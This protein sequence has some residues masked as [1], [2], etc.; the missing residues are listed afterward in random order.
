MDSVVICISD[1]ENNEPIKV[2]K[3]KRTKKQ[4]DNNVAV[5][6]PK[7]KCYSDNENKNELSPNT[8]ISK[9]DLNSP[10]K[11]EKGISKKLFENDCFQSARQALHSCLPEN[12]PGRER[13]ME[14]IESFVIDRVGG[15]KSGTLYVSGPP[16][17]GKT[18]ALSLILK[19]VKVRYYINYINN[20]ML[21]SILFLGQ[22]VV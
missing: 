13:E 18:A 12:L 22:I 8:L 15:K 11:N 9:L 1:E 6:P 19:K 10:K 16:G 20:N 2:R 14:E 3:S 21:I 17:T 5:T 7:Q 4:N